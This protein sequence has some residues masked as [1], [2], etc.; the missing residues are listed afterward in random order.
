LNIDT[1]GAERPEWLRT[2]IER[3][4]DS[5][6]NELPA[7]AA[8]AVEELVANELSRRILTPK[9]LSAEARKLLDRLDSPGGAEIEADHED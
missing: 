9:Q 5:A 8:K 4:R 2:A 6:G 1:N 7:S 3:A